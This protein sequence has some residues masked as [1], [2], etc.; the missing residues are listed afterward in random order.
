MARRG[1]GIGIVMLV[2]T[3]LVVLLVVA[4]SWRSV[5]PTA[6]AIPD[7]PLVHTVDDAPAGDGDDG[8]GPGHL[9]DLRETQRET[10]AHAQAVQDAMSAIE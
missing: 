6:T 1:S 4:R 7:G 8:S 5:A 9:P 3:L 2:V 10:D